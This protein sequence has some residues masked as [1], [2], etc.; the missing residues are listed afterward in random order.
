MT[1]L[2][3]SYTPWF[4]INSRTLFFQT[5]VPPAFIESANRNIQSLITDI[6]S[7]LSE[8]N[9]ENKTHSR[10]SSLTPRASTEHQMKTTSEGWESTGLNCSAYFFRVSV[11]ICT[12]SLSTVFIKSL[13]HCRLNQ[14]N[15]SPFSTSIHI[16]HLEL[17]M[18]NIPYNSTIPWCQRCVRS[19]R[20]HTV[21]DF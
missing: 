10:S 4:A 14:G 16:V 7:Q 1:H 2:S 19:A 12:L 11:S 6:T 3:R 17:N 15:P 20:R 13:A 21:P 18:R 5:K 9:S 8:H